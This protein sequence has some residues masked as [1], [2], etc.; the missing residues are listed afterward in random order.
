MTKPITAATHAAVAAQSQEPARQHQRRGVNSSASQLKDQRD[1]E[2]QT[3][4][5]MKRYTWTP[6]F[7]CQRE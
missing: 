4:Y 5:G 2:Q 3:N 6:P 7:N 1:T